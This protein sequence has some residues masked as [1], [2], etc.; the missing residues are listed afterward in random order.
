[1][2]YCVTYC[3]SDDNTT[4]SESEAHLTETEEAQGYKIINGITTTR[5]GKLKGVCVCHGE[6]F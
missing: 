6:Q 2:K 3:F 5:E 4:D 1:V